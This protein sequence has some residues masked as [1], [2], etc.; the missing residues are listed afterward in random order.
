MNLADVIVVKGA[1]ENEGVIINDLVADKTC[2]KC[3]HLVRTAAGI[4]LSGVL[5][6]RA[7]SEAMCPN[8]S[9]SIT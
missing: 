1:V 6:V 5:N 4:T 2:P 7:G 9:G 3:G 8:C